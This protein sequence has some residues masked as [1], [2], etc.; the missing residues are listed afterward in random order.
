MH[1][2]PLFCLFFYASSPLV[3]NY[4]I[5]LL[6]RKIAAHPS[7]QSTPG[8]QILVWGGLFNLLP[9]VRPC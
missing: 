5:P 4:N 1:E 3:G 6:H 9:K 8:L 2:I 7:D